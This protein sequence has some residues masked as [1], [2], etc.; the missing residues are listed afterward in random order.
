M[1]PF[2]P[3]LFP[4]LLTRPVGGNPQSDPDREGIYSRTRGNKIRSSSRC[5]CAYRSCVS[6]PTAVYHRIA[7]ANHSIGGPLRMRS[8]GRPKVTAMRPK[9]RPRSSRPRTGDAPL[10]PK[11]P[12]RVQAHVH[13]EPG[14]SSLEIGGGAMDVESPGE[15]VEKRAVQGLLG[16]APVIEAPGQLDEAVD[17]AVEVGGEPVNP[18]HPAEVGQVDRPRRERANALDKTWLSSAAMIRDSGI[19]T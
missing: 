19:G 1:S 6:S 18:R 9:R 2:P 13:R 14:L 3:S 4:H 15:V 8:V 7:H 10:P 11:E 12:R 5:A 17:V 16:I